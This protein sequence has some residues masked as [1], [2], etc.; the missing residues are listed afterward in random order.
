MRNINWVNF[1]IVVAVAALF[2]GE[3]WVVACIVMGA[4]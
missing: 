2:V 3:A 1:A 4:Q